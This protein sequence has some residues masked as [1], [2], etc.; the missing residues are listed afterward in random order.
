MLLTQ[1]IPTTLEW[2]T[3]GEF[4][5]YHGHRIFFRR[6]GNGPV[7]VLLHGFPTASWDWAKLW[8]P[9]AARFTLI[10]PDF[11][12]YGFSA[13]PPRYDYRIA[14]QADLLEALLARVGVKRV[15][16]LAHDVGD[17]V[18]QEL[19]ARMRDGEAKL[20]IDSVCLLNGGLF[21]ETHR[22]RFSQRVLLSPAGLW[23]ARRMTL[24]RFSRALSAIFGS[25]T[26]PDSEELAAWWSLLNRHDGREVIPRLIYYMTERKL[27]R[28]RWVGALAAA[29][30]PIRLIAGAD[31][32]V[33]GEHMTRRYRELV[34]HADVV[35]LRGIG[36][37]PH[38]EAPDVT[39]QAY[40][41]FMDAVVRRG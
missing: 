34:P 28:A 36:H 38:W 39:L 35:L 18:A 24:R 11:L 29:A 21:P 19:L 9:L 25:A 30:V 22:P 6:Q 20:T 4:F 15:H 2:L 31:D 26:Q 40:L 16:L 7:L 27:Q 14:D 12:G 13:K 33:S 37:F 3:A 23:F 5:S 10:A 32:P 1:K 8:E 17:T 41:A